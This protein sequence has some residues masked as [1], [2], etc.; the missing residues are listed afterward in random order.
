MEINEIR[1]SILK[2]NV[3]DTVVQM[4]LNLKLI[5]EKELSNF[6]I[7]FGYIFTK[8]DG[9]LE[10]LMKAICNNKIFYLAC[11]KGS[12]MLININ[13]NQY[14]YT[15]NYMKEYHPCLNEIAI[16]ESEVQKK[17]REKNNQ[18]LVNNGISINENLLCNE[19][20]V[21]IKSIDEICKRAIACLLTIQLSCD[22]NNGID[23]KSEEYKENIDFF[24]SLYKKYDVEEY[25]NSKERR[26]VD[27]TYSK[28]DAIDMDW[29]Y[30]AYWA[31]CWCLSLV[32]NIKDGGELCDCNKA[33]SF[34]LTS[35]S[36]NDFKNKCH[37]RDTDEILDMLDLYYRYNWAINHKH[38]DSNTKI[39][40]LNP[41]N[42]I[43]RRI[44]LEWVISSENDW[45]D[46]QMNA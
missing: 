32:D 3:A 12:V 36:F 20:N 5:D 1:N 46:I 27:G 19:H 17:R 7:Q 42:V 39:G 45:Y 35:K 4:L 40:N 18:Y 2:Q 8:V 34:V 24:K 10:A 33:V 22:I 25:L 37:L 11:Q 30:E 14:N 31:L 38:I 6:Q 15:I 43:E 9:V 28:Q 41:S 23:I 16:N 13:E 26:I 29:A 21:Q 44:S